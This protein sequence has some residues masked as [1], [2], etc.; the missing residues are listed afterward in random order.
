MS[1]VNKK[2]FGN[3][4]E[5]LSEA[6]GIGLFKTMGTSLDVIVSHCLTKPTLACGDQSPKVGEAVINVAKVGCFSKLR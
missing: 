4:K 1:S 6:M 2:L 5:L 3:E